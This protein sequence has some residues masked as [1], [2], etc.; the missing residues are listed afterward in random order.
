MNKNLD[1]PKA[2]YQKLF[3]KSIY[4]RIWNNT[5]KKISFKRSNPNDLIGQF[6]Q[7]WLPFRGHDWFNPPIIFFQVVTEK[8]E[9]CACAI[10]HVGPQIIEGRL[11]GAIRGRHLQLHQSWAGSENK[12]EPL[13]DANL[14]K[15]DRNS[16]WNEHTKAKPAQGSL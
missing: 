6:S 3:L 8:C 12:I 16:D 15:S 2:W 14:S 10:Y 7:I 9:V 4:Y 1:M 5:S 13:D 11:R